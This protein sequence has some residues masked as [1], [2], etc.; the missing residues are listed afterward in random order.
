[1]AGSKAREYKNIREHEHTHYIH[2][3]MNPHTTF[4]RTNMNTDIHKTSIS[5]ALYINA[6]SAFI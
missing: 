5:S 1:M 2:T 6:G 4:M 3:C